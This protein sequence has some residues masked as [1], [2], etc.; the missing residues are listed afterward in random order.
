MDYGLARRVPLGVAIVRLETIIRA[1]AEVC[2]DA[3]RDI[4][5]HE[6][7]AGHTGERAVAGVTSGLI[8]LGETV[9]FEGRHF[10]ISQRL[11]SKIVEFDP[12]HRF[13]DEMQEGAFKRMRHIHEFR[14]VE[15]ATLMVD[16]LDFASPLGPI[17]WIVDLI[18]LRSY[19]RGF[20]AKRNAELK[21]L[22]EVKSGSGGQT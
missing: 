19:M 15:G 14:E 7:T 12:P 17:G 20:V 8:S 11:T 22:I 4:T 18:F 1:P 9:T 13:V 2:F 10:G 5:L 3:A 21:R 16:T 6:Q